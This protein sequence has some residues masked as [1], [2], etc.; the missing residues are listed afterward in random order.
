[1]K[2][3]LITGSDG[4]VG[5]HLT[6]ALERQKIKVIRFSRS[7]DKQLVNQRD[8]AALPKV[9]AVFHLAAV[10]GY[11]DCNTNTKLAYQVNVLGTVNVL[12]YCR[13]TGAKLIF[14]STYV[15]DSPYE[16]YKKESDPVKPMTHYSMT[17]W[18]GEELCRFYSRVFDVNT[19]ILR[20]ANV[21]G[22]GQSDIYLIPIIARHLTT[23]QE[24][25]LTKPEIERSFIYIDDLIQAYIK[26][27]LAKTE[28]GEA[29]N[30]SFP[31]ATP[32][33]ELLNTVTKVTGKTVK[34]SYSG[35]GRPYEI[36][37]NRMNISKLRQTLNWQPE[38][39]LKQGLLK[40]Q[41]SQYF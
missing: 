11:R 29:F 8:F 40:L 38:T 25:K 41:R 15:Y 35:T 9:D 14:P 30:V 37:L 26:L 13:R 16:A 33:A 7:L 17:K 36:D 6:A 5:R 19:L 4:F 20:T 1:M 12:E 3:A 22:A 2:T 31:R 23:N 34:V 24:M 10:S 28:P 27:A 21:Y 39:T 32:I 18:L